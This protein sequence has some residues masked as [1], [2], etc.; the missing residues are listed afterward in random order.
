MKTFIICL[1]LLAV[2]AIPAFA[3]SG[4]H[5][6]DTIQVGGEGGWDI[7]IADAK[8]K[9]LYV[10]HGTHVVVIDTETDKVVGDIPKTNG[11][12]GIAFGPEHG[13]TTNG[14]DNAVTMF[15]LKDLA[16]KATIPTG[17]N[18][19]ALVYDKVSGNVF[20]FTP[21]SND[22]TVI[23]EKDGKVV[24]TIPLGGKPEFGVSDEKGKI[25]VNLEDKSSI[26]EIDASNYYNEH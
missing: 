9:R 21:G 4:Y 1:S 22:C 15:D 3:Q 17:K 16:V 14:R 18:P 10:S 20:V 8:N 12:H 5:L 13:F 25:F 24:G 23:N 2:L 19:D 26:V 6:V 11:V 7:L